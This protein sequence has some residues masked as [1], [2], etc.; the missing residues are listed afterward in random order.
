MMD[1]KLHQDRLSIFGLEDSWRIGREIYKEFSMDGSVMKSD[2]IKK[3]LDMKY[4]YS[5]K[6]GKTYYSPSLGTTNDT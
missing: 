1:R 3:N 6:E 5:D 4:G 2:D